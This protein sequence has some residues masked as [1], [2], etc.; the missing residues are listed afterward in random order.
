MKKKIEIAAFLILSC[1]IIA[2][3]IRTGEK[4]EPCDKCLTG[5]HA[6]R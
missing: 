4:H 2:L 3:A 6:S 1:V 5:V